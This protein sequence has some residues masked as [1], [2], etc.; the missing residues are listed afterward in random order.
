MELRIENTEMKT[1]GGML[2]WIDPD[3]MTVHKEFD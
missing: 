1:D 2:K 3:V